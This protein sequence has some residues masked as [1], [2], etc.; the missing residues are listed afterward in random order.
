VGHEKSELGA[1]A[2]SQRIRFETGV[3]RSRIQFVGQLSFWLV[4][5]APSSDFESPRE[6]LR[7]D[8]TSRNPA[9]QH[10]VL[11]ECAI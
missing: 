8:V 6:S 10:S 11:N 2:T 5:I 1:I 3:D 4:A 9:L 7:K